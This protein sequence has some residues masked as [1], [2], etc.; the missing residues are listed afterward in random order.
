[1][2]VSVL[3][4]VS[5]RSVPSWCRMQTLNVDFATSMPTAETRLCFVAIR[6]ALLIRAVTSVRIPIISVKEARGLTQ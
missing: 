6:V 2:S 5:A 4:I 3:R 1:M